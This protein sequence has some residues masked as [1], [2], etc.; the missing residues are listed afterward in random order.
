MYLS[1]T[2]N[3][4]KILKVNIFSIFKAFVWRLVNSLFK[5]KNQAVVKQEFDVLR[6]E[7]SSEKMNILLSN[8]QVCA[9]DIR[10]LDANSKQCL[11]MLCLRTCLHNPQTPLTRL[12]EIQ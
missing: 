2:I 1:Q 4:K 10:C 3:E 5:H 11:K 8:R 7:I 12:R 9:A 6:F